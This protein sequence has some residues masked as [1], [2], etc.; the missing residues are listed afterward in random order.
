MAAEKQ[1]IQNPW[2]AV[3]TGC[4]V[5]IWPPSPA[6]IIEP[7]DYVATVS[8]I[9]GKDAMRQ[10]LQTG[11]YILK[12]NFKS[13]YLLKKLYYFQMTPRSKVNCNTF[14]R[15]PGSTYTSDAL[16]SLRTATAEDGSQPVPC[17]AAAGNHGRWKNNIRTHCRR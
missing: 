9:S 6:Y 16:A 11:G 10:Q 13:S 8:M 12:R 4:S 1:A 2:T 15:T 5:E 7:L 14:W 3:C 17:R